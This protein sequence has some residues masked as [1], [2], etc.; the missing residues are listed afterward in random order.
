MLFNKIFCVNYALAMALIAACNLQ[1]MS[2]GSVA[3]VATG[4]A[5]NAPSSSNALSVSAPVL[6][7]P[8]NAKGAL[9]V[10]VRSRIKPNEFASPSIEGASDY[11]RGVRYF[12]GAGVTKDVKAAV[13]CWT[14][15]AAKGC[16]RSQYCLGDCYKDGL[17]VSSDEVKAL[18]NYLKSAKQGITP[19][20]KKYHLFGI[21]M[22]EHYPEATLNGDLTSLCSLKECYLTGMDDKQ[23]RDLHCFETKAA[24][25][26]WYVEHLINLGECWLYGEH[27][28][29]KNE[30]L[31]VECFKR[32]IEEGRKNS[33]LSYDKALVYLG[34][35]YI[36]ALGLR[37]DEKEAV[38]LFEEAANKCG[39]AQGM[40]QLGICFEEGRGVGKD[41]KHAINLFRSAEL[42]GD[43]VASFH[44][45]ACYE[46][47]DG[48]AQDSR[49]AIDHYM[50]AALLK[51]DESCYVLGDIYWKGRLVQK[52]VDIAIFWL[53][54]AIEYGDPGQAQALLDEIER[55]RLQSLGEHGE[56]PSA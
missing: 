56:N 42:L 50:R 55:Q 39:S 20:A 49:K 30:K 48:V 26:E 44:L 25:H 34:H 52:D 45:G 35:C 16:S 14:E 31:A 4:S 32:A 29:A 11:E 19:A 7:Q 9:Q 8:E 51:H 36:Y 17:G 3:A 46:V 1:A 43:V 23:Y 38:V 41:V 6:G 28:M 47:G 22:I 5:V 54:K 37:K 33:M 12:Q 2:G 24:V 40:T 27:G 18:W 53:N 15:G 10:V 13:A 21:D